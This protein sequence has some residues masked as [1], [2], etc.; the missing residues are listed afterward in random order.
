MI[1][2][3]VKNSN[4]YC[5]DILKLFFSLC[6]VALHTHLFLDSNVT[7]HWYSSHCIWRIAVPFFFVTSGYFFSKKVKNSSHPKKVLF[8]TI[9]RLGTLLIFWLIV[10]L[11]LQ[12]HSLLLQQLSTDK[13]IIELIRSVIFYP[14]GAL[15]YILALIV[16]YILIYP[17][18]KRK[19]YIL[20]LI[21]GFLLYLFAIF[22]NS[23]YFVIEGTW[24]Q[25]IIDDYLRI[26]ISSRNGLFVGFFYVSIG[27]YL[28]TKKESS[29]N[30]NIFISIIGLV[31]LILE[32]AFIRDKHYIEDNSLFF[33]LLIIVPAIFELAKRI[34]VK[35]DSKKFRNLSIG[36]YV[37]HRPILG[38][39][40][41]FFTIKSNTIL[42][43]IVSV[44]SIGISYFLQKINNK[45]INKIIT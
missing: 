45:Y 14:W 16:A 21:I 35:K 17:F 28:T 38:Y 37:L 3:E 20:P 40:T 7:L 19:K 1:N 39:L 42:F 11:P 41:Y 4:Y 9:R 5:I 22:S 12:I 2:K 27:N 13:I 31:G 6:I 33:S 23:Y 18:L 34:N 36:I 10:S 26:F 30:K 24:L 32:T 25:S 44:L 8:N 29:I 43:L 15:W